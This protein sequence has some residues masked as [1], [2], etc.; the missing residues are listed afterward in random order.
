MAQ[1]RAAAESHD[2]VALRLAG[3]LKFMAQSMEYPQPDWLTVDHLQL[4]YS[5]LDELG[6]NEALEALPHQ[7]HILSEL[8]M[9][10]LQVEYTRMF[11]NAIP[12]IVAPPYGSVYTDSEG[13]LFGPSAE[14]T[15][16]F[17]HQQGFDLRGP[18]DIP[19]H[20]NHELRFLSLLL[21]DGKLCESEQFMAIYF[22][23]WFQL[24]HD[25]VVTN[26]RHPYFR[27]MAELIHFFTKE[28]NEHD[29]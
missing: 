26:T 11:I 20:L 19:D 29:N 15:K 16:R 22:R 1:C 3:W 27:I 17:Y 21:Q 7:D 6:W 23:P 24:F 10:E 18:N 5:I 8:G 28:D 13:I 4:L 14:K 12:H 2:A 25:R 9:V